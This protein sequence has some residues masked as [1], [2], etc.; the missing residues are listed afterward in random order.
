MDANTISTENM[1]VFEAIS[2]L[3]K[4]NEFCEATVQF[5]GTHMDSF[6]EEDENKLEYTDIHNEFV[7]VNEDVI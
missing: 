6:D 5:L 1:A 2:A 7:R 3:V 4:D